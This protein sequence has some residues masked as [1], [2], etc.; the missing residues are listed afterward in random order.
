MARQPRWQVGGDIVADNIVDYTRRGKDGHPLTR[1]A[2]HDE[3]LRLRADATK[4]APTRSQHNQSFC[5]LA[6]RVGPAA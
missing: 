6:A 1:L 2:E 4:S 3:V 5:W